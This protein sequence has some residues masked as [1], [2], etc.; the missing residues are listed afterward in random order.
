VGSTDP[1]AA[2]WFFGRKNNKDYSLWTFSKIDGKKMFDFIDLFPSTG[3]VLVCLNVLT[4]K[5]G[6]KMRKLDVAIF[7]WRALSLGRARRIKKI[8]SVAI[9]E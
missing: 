6:S 9:G 4:V 7:Y 5:I 3:S 1:I 8:H 2:S